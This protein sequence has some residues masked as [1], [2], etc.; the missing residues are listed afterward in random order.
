MIKLKNPENGATVSQKTGI[1]KT[2]EE[3]V[4]GNSN[5]IGWC[6]RES[7]EFGVCTIPEPVRFRWGPAD[8]EVLFE[9]S[10][11]EDFSRIIISSKARGSFD[12]YGLFI[13][14]QYW[15]RAGDSAPGTFSTED[16]TPRWLFVEGAFNV[17]DIGGYTNIDGRRIRQGLLYR[18]SK[19]DPSTDGFTITEKGKRTLK[20][21]MGIRHELDLRGDGKFEMPAGG[22]LGPDVRYTDVK[23]EDYE[24]FLEKKDD[25]LTM[26]GV[27]SDPANFPVYTH[28]E[29]GADRTGTFVALLEGLLRFDHEDICR[30]FEMT[31]LS[32]PEDSRSRNEYN[33]ETLERGLA[34]F[35]ASF[36]ESCYNHALW[37]GADPEQIETIRRIFIEGYQQDL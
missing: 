15:W 32:F 13:G 19:F 29:G 21:F 3:N 17:R 31:T 37:C 10:E 5:V 23:S 36:Q 9:L 6:S 4:E 25:Y 1:M 35:G 8:E 34:K 24:L 28:C 14:R 22:M 16:S 11:T 20:E 33:W 2:F 12:A 7:R 30:D 27:V 18:G 26:L